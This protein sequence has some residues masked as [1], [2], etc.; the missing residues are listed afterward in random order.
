M[1]VDGSSCIAPASLS[2]TGN[3]I[4]LS[5]FSIGIDDVIGFSILSFVPVIKAWIRRE[6]TWI[7]NV[8]P[9]ITSIQVFR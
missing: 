2:Y 7:V 5:Y 9:N 3:N 1:S 6:I 4:T 8:T